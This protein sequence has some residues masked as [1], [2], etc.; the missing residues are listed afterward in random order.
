MDEVGEDRVRGA[1]RIVAY[2]PLRLLS[3]DLPQR[4][5]GRRKLTPWR[6]SHASGPTG[7]DPQN[8]T[9]DNRMYDLY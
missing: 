4:V 1:A 6:R 8:R 2:W 7:K 9:C 3:F 5:K